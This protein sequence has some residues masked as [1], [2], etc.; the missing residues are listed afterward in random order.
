MKSWMKH[1]RNGPEVKGG[2]ERVKVFT[3][4]LKIRHGLRGLLCLSC[5]PLKHQTRPCEEHHVLWISSAESRAQQ[6]SLLAHCLLR[7]LAPSW[8]SQDVLLEM[9]LISGTASSSCQVHAMGYKDCE[10]GGQE[11]WV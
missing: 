6:T 1:W 11:T 8:N 10:L 5:T 7:V 4:L 3:T 2:E 9:A